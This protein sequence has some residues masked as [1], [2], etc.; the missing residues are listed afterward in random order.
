MRTGMPKYDKTNSTNL[1][2]RCAPQARTDFYSLAEKENNPDKN[3]VD[4]DFAFTPQNAPVVNG[5][6]LAIAC[7][8]RQQ[9]CSMDFA[10]VLDDGKALL[11]EMKFNVDSSIH[12]QLKSI[13]KKFK[14]TYN[15]LH[16]LIAFFHNNSFVLFNEDRLQEGISVL[17]RLDEEFQEDALV[18][19]LNLHFIAKTLP[20]FSKDFF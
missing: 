11:G 1:V 5:D 6:A 9:P 16:A 3:L 15:N 19:A 13:L 17:S 14:G 20:S 8:P 4:A 7:S 2:M 18:K 10:F 12:Q